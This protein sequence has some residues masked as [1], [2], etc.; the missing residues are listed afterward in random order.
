VCYATAGAVLAPLASPWAW[1][2]VLAVG[3]TVCV[4][5]PDGDALDERGLR[6]IRFQC[7][8]WHGGAVMTRRPWTPVQGSVARLSTHARVGVVRTEGTPLAYRP[9]AELVVLFDR[10]REL[11]RATEGPLVIRSSTV[12]RPAGDVAPRTPA[13]SDGEEAARRGYAEL[14]LV[15]C[16]RR[17]SRRV[18]IAVF[19]APDGREDSERL[20]ERTR[21]LTDSL[22]EFGVRARVLADR[23]LGD[24]VRGFGWS[25][26]PGPP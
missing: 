22:A 23:S 10:F 4:W 5:R 17:R 21:S 3:F 11:L 7:Q 18:E 26:A 15:L 14:A 1:V 20:N 25:L 13:F 6:W 9:P 2:P 16:R 24:A 8:R 12:P 19:G